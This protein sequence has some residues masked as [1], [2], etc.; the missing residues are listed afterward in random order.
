VFNVC[1]HKESK[2]EKKIRD[3]P[4]LL[5]T[6][7]LGQALTE[8]LVALVLLQDAILNAKN[9]IKKINN[10]DWKKYLTI[11]NIS[12]FFIIN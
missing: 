9:S 12:L 8:Y 11:S 7:Q 2:T 1:I 10:I 3:N 6:F 5:A 4:Y